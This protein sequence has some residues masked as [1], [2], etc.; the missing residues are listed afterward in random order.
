MLRLARDG[1]RMQ[2]RAPAARGRARIDRTTAGA[3]RTRRRVDDG[4]S[5]GG[6]TPRDAGTGP[7][8]MVMAWA[9][10]APDGL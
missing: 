1:R 7:W 4:R 3:P 10:V 5:D 2:W 6:R 8:S 9:M